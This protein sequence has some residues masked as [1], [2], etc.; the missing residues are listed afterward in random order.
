MKMKL[1]VQRDVNEWIMVDEHCCAELKHSRDGGALCNSQFYLDDR[2]EL[3]LSKYIGDALGRRV[4]RMK[5]CPHCYRKF[6]ATDI[7][8]SCRGDCE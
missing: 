8:D 3:Y 7:V 6:L 2:G 4:L 5:C 1:H